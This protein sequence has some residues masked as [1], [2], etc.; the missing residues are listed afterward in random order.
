MFPF[1]LV[2]YDIML[3]TGVLDTVA[4]L[5]GKTF[6]SSVN[7]PFYAASPSATCIR[8]R[9]T[10]HKNRRQT[11][12]PNRNRQ[13]RTRPLT[14]SFFSTVLHSYFFESSVSRFVCVYGGARPIHAH[15]SLVGRDCCHFHPSLTTDREQRTNE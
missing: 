7:F 14:S 15:I 10:A 6:S 8:L 12:M 3:N 11:F 1:T 13:R 5:N 2:L 9:R 4:R